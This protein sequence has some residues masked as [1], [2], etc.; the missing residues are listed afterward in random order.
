MIF[1]YTVLYS[2]I[3]DTRFCFFLVS[4]HDACDLM[5]FYLSGAPSLRLLYFAGIVLKR[6]ESPAA[7]WKATVGIALT[8]PHKKS[9]TSWSASP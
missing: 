3:F 2:R 9:I 5:G 4:G 6:T 8:V 1:S 7:A